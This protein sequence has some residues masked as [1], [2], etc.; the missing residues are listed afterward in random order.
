[1]KSIHLKAFFFY[2]SRDFKETASITDIKYRK[3]TN[4]M[5][6]TLQ[7]LLNHTKVGRAR[8]NSKCSPQM[9]STSQSGCQAPSHLTMIIIFF[10]YPIMSTAIV[11]KN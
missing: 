6:L 7:L 2:L 11:T 8:Q 3:S 9:Q 4:K 10:L 1:M 5:H